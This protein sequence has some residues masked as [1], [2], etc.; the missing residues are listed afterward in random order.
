[1]SISDVG[2]ISVGVSN[3]AGCE[4]GVISVLG[5]SGDVGF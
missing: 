3:G 4:G 1:M 2:D 5:A